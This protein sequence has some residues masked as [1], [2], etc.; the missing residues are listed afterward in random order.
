MAYVLVNPDGT[1]KANIGDFVITGGGIFEKTESGSRFVSGLEGLIGKAKTGS[2]GDVVAAYSKVATTKA[3]PSELPTT[4]EVAT[5]VSVDENG[6]VDVSVSG[7]DPSD[8]SVA[9]SGSGLSNIV[10][11]VVLFLVGVA[12]LDRFINRG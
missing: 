3:T 5:P 2:Y 4:P 8:Y 11:Y 9:S 10:G 7:Y 1:S 12:L 6:L